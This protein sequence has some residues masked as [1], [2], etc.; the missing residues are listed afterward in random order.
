VYPSCPWQVH[1]L[2]YSQAL[3]IY[4]IKNIKKNHCRCFVFFLGPT[5]HYPTPKA[6]GYRFGIF[7]PTVCLSGCHK[8]VGA[9][10]QNLLQFEHETSGVYRSHWGEVHCTR[11]ITLHFLILE[12]LPFVVFFTL[13]FCVRLSQ[14]CWGYILKTKYYR[15]K[16]DNS[17]VYRS[18]WG[19]V[20][21]TRT[22]TLYF[23]ILELLPF[24]IFHTWIMCLCHKLV[25]AISQRLLQIWTW[26]FRG[27]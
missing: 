22:I 13:E 14:T 20:H 5:Y 1:V 16:H 24:V 25:G 2:D 9:I 19:E 15:F 27:V 3:L 23:L 4:I 6:E 8:L 17:R 18:H 7:R 10:S 12:L 11:T 26:N 21:C